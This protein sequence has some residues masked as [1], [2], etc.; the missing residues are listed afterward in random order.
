MKKYEKI[1]IEFLKNKKDILE[2]YKKIRGKYQQLK[3][4]IYK[5]KDIKNFSKCTFQFAKELINIIE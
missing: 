3:S 4:A 2:Q 5:E 1:K